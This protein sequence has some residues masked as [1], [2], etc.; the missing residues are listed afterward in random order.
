MWFAFLHRSR[1]E[2]PKL[3][4]G[5]F[6]DA[7][8][9]GLIAQK[10]HSPDDFAA[11]LGGYSSPVL[12]AR[13]EDALADIPGC[14]AVTL[15]DISTGLWLACR[16][17]EEF[18]HL[19]LMVAS[20]REMFFG[21]A[22]AEVHAAMAG[23]PPSAPPHSH[24]CEITVQSERMLH[25]FLRGRLH[26]NYVLSVACRLGGNFGMVLSKARQALPGIEVAV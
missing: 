20:V 9:G 26:P 15:V 2:K 6:M 8:G 1:T 13:M 21:R 14:L 17:A 11:Q 24:F 18:P 5:F 25:V 19:P 22:V 12:D 10:F 3:I 16:M 4:G 7:S 23:G